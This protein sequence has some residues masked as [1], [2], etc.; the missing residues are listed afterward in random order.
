MVHAYVL[1]GTRVQY[2]VV[3]CYTVDSIVIYC[4]CSDSTVVAY[5]VSRENCFRAPKLCAA[6]S[7]L[8]NSSSDATEEPYLGFLLKEPGHAP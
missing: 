3:L 8:R 6:V 7:A 2:T 1:Y 4:A 5:L